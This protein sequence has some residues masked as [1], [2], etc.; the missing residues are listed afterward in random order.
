MKYLTQALSLLFLAAFFIC[1][2]APVGAF[3]ASPFFAEED[4]ASNALF[5]VS[6]EEGEQAVARALEEEGVAQ[7]IAARITSVSSDALYRSDQP[8]H[9]EVRTLKHDTASQRFSANLLFLNGEEVVSAVPVSGR[10]EEMVLISVARQ[11]I[12]RGQV[13]TEDDLEELAYPAS[14]MRKDTVLAMEDMIG[15]MPRRTISQGRPVRLSELGSP[16]VLKK[17][18]EVRM[19]YA[20][21]YMSI[22]ALGEAMEDGAEGERV[23][24]RNLSSGAVVE[25][26]IASESEVWV[27]SSSLSRME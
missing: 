9:V 15:K 7:T 18:A 2:D 24:I 6:V 25:A 11:R 16:R 19:R 23:R 13:I 5:A 17:G 14:R 8:L 21:P 4:A 1:A 22:S 26:Q 3:A 20:T 10:F 27:G 12:T